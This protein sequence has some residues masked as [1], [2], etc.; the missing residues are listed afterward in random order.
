MVG[1]L[2]LNETELLLL[3]QQ[4]EANVSAVGFSLQLADVETADFRGTESGN[5]FE[6]PPVQETDR[7][8]WI[9]KIKFYVPTQGMPGESSNVLLHV[10]RDGHLRCEKHVPPELADQI[11][12]EIGRIR[13][14]SEYLRP[15]NELIESYVSRQFQGR[16][17][18]LQE[19][20]RTEVNRDFYELAS[21]RLPASLSEQEIRPYVSI[22]SNIGVE[23]CSNGVPPVGSFPEISLQPMPSFG[24]GDGRIEDF[25]QHY[26]TWVHNTDSVDYEELVAHIEHLFNR[27]W[28][29]GSG[30]GTP[31]DM[32]EYSVELYDLSA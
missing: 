10:Y 13:E 2:I 26:S 8:G 23:L 14:Y 21:N 4:M 20:Y 25:F 16:P 6:A 12:A 27:P 29:T 15:L 31:L 17:R 5:I 30:M 1:D 32:I 9:R 7:T 18:T 3:S 22:I 19:D 11:S 28:A 24:V